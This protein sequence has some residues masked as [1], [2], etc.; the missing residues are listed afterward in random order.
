MKESNE[1]RARIETLLAEEFDLRLEESLQPLPHRCRHNH[2]QPIDSRR[3]LMG[4][5]NP[6]YNRHDRVHLPMAPSIGLCLLG[7]ENPEEWGGTICDDP[8]DAQRCPH[9]TPTI[10]KD[11]LLSDFHGQVAD[12]EWLRANIPAVHELLWVLQATTPNY[13]LPWWKRLLFRFLGLRSEP[14]RTVPPSFL[15]SPEDTDVH[16]T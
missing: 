6:G 2:R 12:P 14:I 8:I 7:S 10:S 9:F 11:T 15:L 1:I 16:G 5:N 4:E 3:H 13:H